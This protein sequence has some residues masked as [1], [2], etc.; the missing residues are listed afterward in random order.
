MS[1]P[2]LT[3]MSDDVPC[4]RVAVLVEALPA[5]AA[6]AT[7]WRTVGP[8][9]G[10]GRREEVRGAL[11]VPVSGVLSVI[12]FEAPLDVEV[13]YQAAL[14]DAAGAVIEWTD[15]ASTILISPR[16]EDGHSRI[17]VHNPLDPRTAMWVQLGKAAASSVLK[18]TP[19]VVGWAEGRR[20]GLVQGGRRRGMVGVP[21]DVVTDT[22]ED[23]QRFDALFGTVDVQRLPIL[24]IRIPRELQ[25][26][27]LPAVW[28]AAVLE[29]SAE[30]A[31]WSD[32]IV[33]RMVADEV[34]PP[35]PTLVVPLLSRADIAAYYA[36]RQAVRAGNASRLA[37]SRRFEIA[38]S[39]GA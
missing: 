18:P 9:E 37:L 30:H 25:R 7:L 26:T 35:V 4:P 14:F 31:H 27:R 20:L 12:D 22:W 38:G 24:C 32:R 21:L 39:G 19:G 23:G 17:L 34:A 36:S 5:A 11:R 6:T 3:P 8:V 15:Q 28:F 16:W 2:L 1:V 13:T 29:P 33:W 10:G